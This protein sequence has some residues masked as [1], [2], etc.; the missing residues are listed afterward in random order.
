MVIVEGPCPACGRYTR[1]PL[2]QNWCDSC[3]EKKL[4]L[5]EREQ[6]ANFALKNADPKFF[7]SLVN[8]K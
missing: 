4:P 8:T 2:G 1:I 7:N 6:R 5:E 3:P